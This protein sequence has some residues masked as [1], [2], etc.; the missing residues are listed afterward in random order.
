MN[1]NDTTDYHINQISTL[2][3]E[4]TLSC[5]LEDRNNPCRQILKNSTTYGSLLYNFLNSKIDISKIKSLIEIGGGYGWLTR[6]FLNS[7]KNF[8]SSMIDIS[9][10]MLNLQKKT[11]ATFN[12]EFINCDFLSCDPM[13]IKNS[14]LI[15]LNEV[16]GDFPTITE[17]DLKDIIQNKDKIQST[18]DDALRIIKKYSL[19]TPDKKFNFNYGAAKA[20]EKI[21]SNSISYA[22]IS[23]HSCE[24][25]A[26][27]EY[28]EILNFNKSK[29]PEEIKLL[30]HSE[31]TIKF[32]H[33]EKIAQA[34]SYRIIRGQ[35]IDFIDINFNSRVNFA[36][37]SNSS[38]EEHETIQHFVHD[39]YKYEYLILINPEY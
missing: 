7:N 31:Y 21:C 14:D 36:L 37:R 18:Y 33:L 2:K 24:A 22:F 38:N 3:W 25:A 4:L 26:P 8:K 12:T 39:L 16:I 1:L 13:L 29:F 19:E 30:G 10:T 28:R 35:Y 5:M 17:M 23:E 32:S 34:L 15:I 6:D 27:D 20:V 9:E 11:L